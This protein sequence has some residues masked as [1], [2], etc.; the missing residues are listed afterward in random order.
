MKTRS[1]SRV[2]TRRLIGLFV[3]LSV[4]PLGLL[5]FFTLRVSSDA[6]EREAKARVRST[7][8]ASAVAIQ[9]ELQGLA[10]VVESFAARPTL[11]EALANPSG[12][13]PE[14]T[15]FHLAE[16]QQ[17]RSG[18]ATT[19]LAD[20]SGVLI[21]IVPATPSIIGTDFSF[22][23]WYEGATATGRTYVSE[24]YESQATGRPRVVAVTTL[25]R[26]PSDGRVLAILVAA[27]GLD[28]I[29]GFVERFASSQG[30]ELTVTDQR[31]VVVASPRTSL[32]G[33]V[34]RRDDPLVAAALRG[35]SGVTTTEGPGGPTLSAYVPITDVGWT[36]TASV[37]KASAFAA[38]SSLR[39]TV[40][41]LGG[42]LGLV[43]L[44]GLVLLA[45]A[46]RGWERAERARSQL[47][48]IVEST[49][50]AIIGKTLDGAIVSWNSSAERLYG[51][52]AEEVVGQ[53]I[54]ILAPPDRQDEIPGILERIARGERVEHYETVRQRKDGTLVDVSLSVSPVRDAAGNVTGASAIARDITEAKRAHEALRESQEELDRYFTLS[55]DLLC[56]ADLQGYFRRLNPA[57][58]RVL[59]FSREELM[60][61]PFLSFV[62]P[63]D[64]EKTVAEV[65]KLST[66]ANTISFENRYRCWDGSY[67]WFL[68]N[69]TP[70][71]EEGL[72]YAAARDVTDRRLA[73]EALRASEERNRLI[74]ETASDA[75]IEMDQDGLVTGWNAEAEAAFGWSRDQAIGR[76]VAETV[77]PHRFREAHVEGLRHFLVTG[78]GPVLNKRVEL[79]AL[80]QDG[81]EFPVELTVSP[82][83]SNQAVSFTAFIHD[84]AER[85]EAEDAI[86]HAKEE[87]E[88]ANTAKSEFLSRMS[89]ELRTPLNAIIGFSQLLEM[90]GLS[91]E[92]D[93]S[94][95]H[96][97]KG[98]RHL[99]EL[100]NEVLDISRI[101]TGQLRLSLEPV[102]VE[103]VVR[104]ALDLLRPLATSRGIEV[105]TVFSDESGRHVLA[106]HQRLKQVL[107]NLIANAV[108]YNRDA[109]KVT[110]SSEPAPE[111][112]HRI[113]VADTG[114]GIHP[115]KMDR[116][117]SAFE[118]LGADET[119]VEGTGLG[120]VLSKRLVEAMGGT[121]GVES[122]PGEGSTFRVELPFAD[123]IT[124]PP[125]STD[126]EALG[127]T[128][129]S[130][131][132]RTLLYIEDNL[133]NV[134]LLERILD[135]RPEVE[136]ITAMQGGLGLDLARQH[137]P[138]LVLLDLHLP[139]IQGEEVLQRLQAAP[140]TASIP[141]VVISADA[142]PG[143]I[144]RLL[145]AGAH[146]Y[147]TKPLD[148]RQL[149]ELLDQT[150]RQEVP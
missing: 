109:G 147:L 92:Q 6:L 21:D 113:S 40:L 94:V 10:D 140:E 127:R 35:R 146:A 26:S 39:A 120:L 55:L 75:V 58:E 107:L 31:G 12:Y 73:E 134:R 43:L 150:L 84:I 91:P 82:I 46:L 27:Y 11:L 138:D 63:D 79:V 67:R 65:E 50:D 103:E 68:W 17:S 70:V 15:T 126:R 129:G 131:P 142:T 71:V 130:G 4:V 18:I 89:H 56:V 52:S 144:D 47:A 53:P 1:A 108:K 60:A 118:R 3:L 132:E 83:R 36:I 32:E 45:L 34:S 139:D 33:L 101:E 29:Q 13:D 90:D 76:S 86:R 104:E 122:T 66:G 93:E 116:L 7:A 124:V 136:L 95:Q 8:E 61:E 78:E 49:G 110:V 125:D 57:F 137:R 128:G 99:L 25:V 112:R 80:H 117:F 77:I 9:N 97:L 96:I 16:L 100:I 111:E 44:G 23:D 54:A 143:Q 141:V 81:H 42:I 64:R 133:S 5:A 37:P 2:Q 30:V 14:L 48:L 123:A 87:A 28:T 85:K 106:D 72:I 114:P 149:L 51:Y 38:V 69:A 98:G 148:V 20:P 145:S 115:D 121:I 41:S 102:A 22:R 19:F 88:R 62:H 119:G 135:H 59:G 74:I 24:A 105:R